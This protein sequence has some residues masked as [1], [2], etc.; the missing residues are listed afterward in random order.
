MGLKP[1][2]LLS[3]GCLGWQQ[4]RSSARGRRTQTRVLA[5][6]SESRSQGRR[7]ENAV[8][9]MARY[10]KMTLIGARERP[11]GRKGQGCPQEIRTKKCSCCFF[12]PELRDRGEEKAKQ[13]RA[14]R[15]GRLS[16]SE[17]ELTKERE[18]ETRE[19]ERER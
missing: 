8:I 2:L 15:I 16:E 18:R 17:K 19:R 9:E 4:W 11:S 10:Q 5:F 3:G 1:G 6:V 12:F 7:G 13:D 14:T